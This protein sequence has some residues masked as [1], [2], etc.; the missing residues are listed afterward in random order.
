MPQEY[1]F[2][3]DFLVTFQVAMTATD[4]WI[5]ASDTQAT[6]FAGI[7]SGGIRETTD[8]KKIAHDQSSRTTFMVSGDGVGRIAARDIISALRAFGSYPDDDWLEHAMPRIA[9]AAFAEHTSKRQP[10]SP[11]KIILAVQNSRPFWQVWVGKNSTAERV[12]SKTFGGDETNSAKFFVEQY[13]NREATVGTLLPL[14]AHSVLMAGN[15]NPSGVG[16]LEITFWE[17]GGLID[18]SVDSPE[19]RQLADRSEQIDTYVK[20]HLLD[21]IIP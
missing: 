13:Y 19:L 6:Q 15:R 7:A 5:M 12:Y 4:G 8:T 9:S 2:D 10:P 20:T 16:G 17:D 1:R 18:W 3:E 14:A 21:A 11:R